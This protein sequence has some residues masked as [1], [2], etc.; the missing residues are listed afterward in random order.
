MEFIR[1]LHNI[2][3][4]HFGCVLTIGNFDGVHRGHQRVIDGLNAAAKAT[5]LPATV[6]VFEPQPKEFFSPATAP[7]RLSLLRDKYQALAQLGVQRLLC[8]RFDASFANMSAEQ[9]VNEY[10]VAKLGVKALIVGD[11]FRFGKGRTGDF[12][13][14]QQQ[15]V[16]VG[17]TVTNTESFRELDCRVSSTAIREALA[18]SRF[19]DAEL[20]IGQPWLI[21]GKVVHGEKNGRLLGFPTAN[22]L[23]KRTQTPLK[24]VFV[25]RVKWQVQTFW[26][27]A[28][29]GKRPTLQGQRMQ[30]EAH[31]FAC[32]A[33]LY[34]QQLTVQ[35]VHKIREE[36]KFASLE[37][38]QAQIAHDVAYAKQWLTDLSKS[39]M[40]SN[41][42]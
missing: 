31:L 42:R 14:L 13:F 9:F 35:C 11:D 18:D 12:A 8:V 26:G 19:A 41:S 38:L 2:K 20:M 21:S 1:G 37:A 16:S 17:F 32:D 40:E 22:I 28:N 27:V 23:L 4:Q 36:Q 30:V 10:L 33:N 39:E 3:P 5:G 7:A 34:G 6:M 25:V 24:G 15:S 29:V